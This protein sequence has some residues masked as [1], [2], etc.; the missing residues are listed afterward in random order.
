MDGSTDPRLFATPIPPRMRAVARDRYGPISQVEV[1]TVPV[2]APAKDEVLIEV[3]AA[4]LDRGVWHV[5]TGLPYLLRMAGFGLGRPHQPILG[6]DVA[7]RVAAVGR[8]VTHLAVGDVVLGVG[9]GTFAEYACAR[10]DRLVTKPA[11]LSFARAAAAPTSGLAALQAVHGIA[12]VRSGQRVLVL[13]A[14][15]GV[16]SFAV[17]LAT[18]AGAEVTGVAS[19]PKLDLVRSLGA[20]HAV[21]YASADATDGAV[22]YNVI[23]DAGGRIPVP[24]LR[25]AL[26]R[27]GTLVIVGGEGGGRWTGG[28]GRQLRAVALSPWSPQK[29]TTFISSV[30]S[31]RLD[32]LRRALVD[33]LVP[34]VERTYRLDHARH[35]LEDLELGRVRGKTV[36]EVGPGRGDGR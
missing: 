3:R 24:R 29:L 13:G 27:D 7:G 12:E 30:T 9:S 10:A 5:A 21:D 17:Q 1:R 8:A 16:G 31:A 25:R 18:S 36:I 4:G 6:M 34:A 14:S 15:G 22:R 26:A 32:Q 2:P 33:G 23:L 20:C 19:A 35:A 28:V 11:T